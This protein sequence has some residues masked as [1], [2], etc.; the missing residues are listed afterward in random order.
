MNLFP[1][2]YQTFQLIN[3]LAG[4]Y[5]W[6]DDFGIFM[7][8][9]SQY[10]LGAGIVI[11]MLLKKDKAVFWKNFKITA[12]FFAIAI[13]SRFIFGE[14]IKR[15]VARPRPFELHQVTQLIPEDLHM[16]FPSGHMSF[17]FAFS[18]AVYLYNKKAGIIC[19]AAS[20]LM[21]LARIYT[22]VHYPLDILGGMVLGMLIGWGMY[23]VFGRSL[24][25]NKN[26]PIY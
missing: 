2:D 8:V 17:F 5:K 21:G 1:M 24:T 11:F 23:R 4:H 14:I 20:F 16:S 6:L 10:F 12:Y 3:S 7:A 26:A 19:Y 25:K 18:T 15:L 13:V 9:Y 22:G